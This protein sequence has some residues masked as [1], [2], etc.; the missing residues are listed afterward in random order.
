MNTES[1]SM[2]DM[3]KE[4]DTIKEEIF[5]IRIGDCRVLHEVDF[6]VEIIGRIKIGKRSNVY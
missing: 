5:R 4:I 6:G 3:K 1:I 2:E